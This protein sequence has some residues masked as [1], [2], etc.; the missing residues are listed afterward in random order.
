LHANY[1]CQFGQA[2]SDCI[3]PLRD[4]MADIFSIPCQVLH[5]RDAALKLM[6]L[7]WQAGGQDRMQRISA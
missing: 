6:Q 1:K 4:T 3:E 5:K 2:Y 7:G